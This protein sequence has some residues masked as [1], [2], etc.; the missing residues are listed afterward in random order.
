MSGAAGIA[1]VVLAAGSS[2]RFGAENKLLATVAGQ[3]LIMRVLAAIRVAG[4]SP[5]IV[6][7]GH[8]AGRLGDRKS[9]V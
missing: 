5:I 1:A 3:T 4:L 7:T 9:V 6:V 2:R 8:E